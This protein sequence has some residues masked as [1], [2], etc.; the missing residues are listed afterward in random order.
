MALPNSN[1]STTLVGQTLGASSR[2][3][4]TLC[5]HPNINKWSKWKPIRFNKLTGLSEDDFLEANYGFSIPVISAPPVQSLKNE[6]MYLK[7]MGGLDSPYRLGDFRNYNHEALRNVSFL[8]P[9]N[10]DVDSSSIGVIRMSGLSNV[11]SSVFSI[12]NVIKGKY[13]GALVIK[14]DDF[15]IKT[16]TD[17]INSTN[18]LLFS[19]DGCPLMSDVGTVEVVAIVSEHPIPSWVNTISGFITGLNAE[20]NISFREV[21]LYREIPNTYA[22]LLSPLNN[23]DRFK[24]DPKQPAEV[25]TFSRIETSA[26]L[27]SQL[28]GTYKLTGITVTATKIGSNV[29]VFD[30]TFN[31]DNNSSPTILS[32]TTPTGTIGF[33]CSRYE[34][35]SER[36]GLDVVYRMNYIEQ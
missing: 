6:W 23:E 2:D 7:P 16:Q 31:A 9:T 11:D 10:I 12:Y 14:G 21:E 26:T 22:L 28:S 17:P 3:V 32:P 25:V 24:I 8:I 18:T 34:H 30:E 19:L 27:N 4:G 15:T 13:F 35:L 29:V 20:K 1:I 5:T 36:G 33:S